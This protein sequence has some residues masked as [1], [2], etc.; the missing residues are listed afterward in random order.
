MSAQAWITLSQRTKRD[1][2]FFL[3]IVVAFFTQTLKA[4]ISWM[5]WPIDFIFVMITSYDLVYW[6]VKFQVILDSTT[7]GTSLPT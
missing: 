6:C 7:N 5:D 2:D 4:D 3:E 1:R